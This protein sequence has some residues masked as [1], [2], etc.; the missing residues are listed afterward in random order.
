MS[1]KK[2]KDP[3]GRR[4]REKKSIEEI[5]ARDRVLRQRI[6]F[7]ANLAVAALSVL[8]LVLDLRAEGAGTFL[9]FTADSGLYTLAGSAAYAV[10]ALAERIRKKEGSR[11]QRRA[12]RVLRYGSVCCA[13]TSLVLLCFVL[14]PSVGAENTRAILFSGGTLVCGIIVPCVSLLSFMLC[15]RGPALRNRDMIWPLIPAGLYIM[16]LDF[17]NLAGAAD[18]PYTIFQVYRQPPLMS[19]YWF[20]ILLG[21]T[22]VLSWLIQWISRILSLEKGQW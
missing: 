6:A 10:S 14:I 21:L 2:K 8:A 19:V 7:T 5:R 9:L 12:V 17:L 11:R 3:S 13:C 1:L 4:R 18:G 15:E 20:V 16:V 22:A